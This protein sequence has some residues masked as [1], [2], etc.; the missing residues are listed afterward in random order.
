MDPWLRLFRLAARRHGVITTAEALMLGI[1]ASVFHARVRRERWLQPHRGVYVVPGFRPGFLT[2]VVAALCACGGS[3][4]ATADT[5]LHLYDVIPPPRELT[6]VVPHSH[7]APRLAGARV[8]RSRTLVDADRAEV[9]GIAVTAAPRSFVDLAPTSG[10]ERLRSLLIDARQRGVALPIQVIDR[11]ASLSRRVP[12]RD[13]LLFAAADVD[14]VGADSVLTDLVHRRL[15]AEGLR[16][17]AHPVEIA[18]GGRRLHPDITFA[19]CRVCLEC[20]SLAHHGSQRS[21]DV[22]HRKDQAYA[23]AHWRCLRIGWR[24]YDRDWDGFVVT[25]RAALDEWPQMVAA[26]ER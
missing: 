4:L 2:Q 20:D 19:P 16:P 17:D 8:V 12:G 23:E 1:P 26:L 25:V 24:R 9:R 5:A 21:I 7:R 6:L 18:V 15:L 11:T 10:F 22:D 3:A 13:R 14:A